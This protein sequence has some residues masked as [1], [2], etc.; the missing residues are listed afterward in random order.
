MKI[1]CSKK[2]ESFMGRITESV[3]PTSSL[4]GDWNGHLFTVDRKKC[5]I[6]MN[7]KTY[8]SVIMTNVYK[9]DLVDF[10]QKFKERLIQQLEFD[11]GLNELK[12]IKIRKELGHIYLTQT[13][14]DR[15]IQGT[16]N[17]HIEQ[18]KYV[19][20][21]DG[22][23]EFSD[24]LKENQIINST[25]LGTKNYFYGKELMAELLK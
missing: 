3:Q 24:T 10:G 6:F 14:N 1:F 4:F 23:I 17:H 2:M 21:R 15:K 19:G 25:P 11:L 5:L 18:L 9:K 16:I 13:N 7:K 8:Y 22:G 20:Y 12:E